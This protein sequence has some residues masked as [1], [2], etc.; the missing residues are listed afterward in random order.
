MLC[1]QKNGSV[2]G[3]TL[4]TRNEGIPA[5]AA[6]KICQVASYHMKCGKCN[7]N[8]HEG[9]KYRAGG[10]LSQFG[11]VVQKCACL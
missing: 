10:I 1:C 6:N 2:L 5:V 9:H 11:A 8:M 4:N 3:Q 7:R